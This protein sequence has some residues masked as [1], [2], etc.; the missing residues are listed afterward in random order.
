MTTSLRSLTVQL[1]TE[2]RSRIALATSWAP[3]ERVNR[4]RGKM[5]EKLVLP[6]SCVVSLDLLNVKKTN[7]INGT[8]ARPS[9]DKRQVH[10]PQ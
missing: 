4:S 2:R 10:V 9:P 6:R 3:P 8:A 1:G 7:V 5:M